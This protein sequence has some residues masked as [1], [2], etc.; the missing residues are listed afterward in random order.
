MRTLALLFC[1]AAMG[2]AEDVAIK[3]AADLPA[4]DLVQLLGRATG[5]TYLYPPTDLKNRVLGGRYDFQVPKERLQDAA[6]FLIRQCGLDVRP[7]PPVKV[8]LPSTALE[9][10]F[11]APGLET[12]IQFDRGPGGWRKPQD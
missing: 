9:T 8:I 11:R 2:A 10:R 5:A 1:L 7:Y 4:E 3:T 6:D 12:E